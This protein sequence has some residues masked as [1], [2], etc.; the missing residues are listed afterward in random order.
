MIYIQAEGTRFYY[1]PAAEDLAT[2]RLGELAVEE[3]HDPEL[4]ARIRRCPDVR[5]VVFEH[6]AQRS[7]GLAYYLFWSSNP[8]LEVLDRRV[9]AGTYTDADFSG[10][11]K[12][13]YQD[14]FC[15]QCESRWHTLIMDGG[16]A[17]PGAPG[18]AQ[19][20]FG[21]SRFLLCPACRSS[22][23]QAVVK[24]MGPADGNARVPS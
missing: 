9:L 3:V 6:W 15:S 18:L 1:L 19:R 14:T 24:I 21:M 11:V 17:Y 2:I 4:A 5:M 20:K 23:R 8:D 12:T 13:R 22:L 16:D 10:S 7:H